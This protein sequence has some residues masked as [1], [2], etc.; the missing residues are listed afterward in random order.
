MLKK[1]LLIL[2]SFYFLPAG[3]ADRSILVL[4]DSLSASYGIAI[5]DGWVSLLQ[6]K[7]TAKGYNYQVI[8]AS[9]SGDTTGGATA[10]LEKILDHEQPDIAIIELGG[11]DGLRGL[12]IDEIHHNL[13][14]IIQR[15]LRDNISILLVP[16]QIPPNYG[17][18]YTSRFQDIYTQLAGEY[19]LVLGRFILENIVL[20]QPE[21]M[22]DDGIHPKAQAQPIMLDNIWQDLEPMLRGKQQQ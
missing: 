2:L 21:L 13:S 8:N 11:N 4:A 7:L 22:Q 20:E 17:P 19:Q 16:I 1:L 15:L 3:A 18:V 10:R 9:I 6:H 12:P 5:K 14:I